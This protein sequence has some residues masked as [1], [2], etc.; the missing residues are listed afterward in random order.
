MVGLTCS[1]LFLPEL[2]PPSNHADAL[3]DQ[4]PH[5]Q[6]TFLTTLQLCVDVRMLCII[7]IIGA[8]LTRT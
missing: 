8:S 3:S 7:P 2:P 5:E 4:E 1:F 6:V